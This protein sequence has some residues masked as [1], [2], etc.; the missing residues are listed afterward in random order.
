MTSWTRDQR[1]FFY[2][3]I[4]WKYFRKVPITNQRDQNCTSNEV[5][6]DGNDSALQRK[7]YVHTFT[8]NDRN[9][10]AL[11]I[12]SAEQ[13]THLTFI[14]VNKLSVEGHVSTLL[15]HHHTRKTEQ[16]DA[17]RIPRSALRLDSA[18]SASRVGPIRDK[19]K[20]AVQADVQL[21]HNA[22]K[23]LSH[24]QISKLWTQFFRENMFSKF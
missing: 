9:K 1:Q 6:A 4:I 7:Q 15:W 20:F 10:T 22:N 24:K 5:T 3:N 21:N 19:N 16:T 23:C 12:S 14:Y 13:R 11:C 17:E 8:V 18:I 2:T